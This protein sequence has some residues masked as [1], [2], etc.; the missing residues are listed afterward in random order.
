MPWS[1]VIGSLD[2]YGAGYPTAPA[3]EGS[4]LAYLLRESA[5]AHGRDAVFL[6]RSLR[7]RLRA[8][9][10]RTYVICNSFPKSG[11]HLL[12]QILYSATPFDAWGDILSVQ[13]LNGLMNT[14][15]HL[16]W[17]LGSAPDRSI[18][19]AHLTC[20]EPVRRVLASH[21]TK[22]VMIYRDLRDVA[23]SHARWVLREP[24]SYLHETYR[25][26]YRTEEA[27]IMATIRGVPVGR[28]FGSSTS[29]PDIGQRFGLWRGWLDDPSALCVR[30]EDL[31][32]ARGGGDEAIRIDTIARILDHVGSP[33][34]RDEIERRFGSGDLDPNESHTFRKGG[35]G[36]T[37]GWRD[38]LTDEHVE[39]FKCV[40]GDLLVDL[41]YERDL[42]W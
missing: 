28:P 7:S 9:G 5:R 41:G 35:G 12:F 17:K 23:V 36:R 34:E 30:F 26:E 10:R 18:V 15:Q 21:D 22:H 8:P 13:A 42:D 37:G 39:A 20:T 11:T 27:C 14:E 3:R 33:L 25:Q 24:R 32:G 38:H 1:A 4:G 16:R 29:L 31:V 6:A 2:Q 40:A 19:R